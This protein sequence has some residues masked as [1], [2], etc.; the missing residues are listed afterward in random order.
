MKTPV[1]IPCVMMSRPGKWS[2]RKLLVAV[3][4]VLLVALNKRLGL[5]LSETEIISLVGLAA[6]YI[7]G[8]L[9]EDTRPGRMEPEAPPLLADASGMLQRP[10]NVFG[11][12]PQDCAEPLSGSEKDLFVK[13]QA[14][15]DCGGSCR[16]AEPGQ[17]KP[18]TV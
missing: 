7:G 1:D 15:C 17:P 6:A 16:E 9:Y 14:G 18:Q 10:G 2:S 13:R 5:E 11:S 3:G 4:V 8:Q 12:I